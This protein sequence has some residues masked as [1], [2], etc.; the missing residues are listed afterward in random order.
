MCDWPINTDHVVRWQQGGS[1]DC[2]DISVWMIEKINQQ[3][4]CEIAIKTNKF[5]KKKKPPHFA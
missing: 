2:C 5:K 4:V 1:L 3:F